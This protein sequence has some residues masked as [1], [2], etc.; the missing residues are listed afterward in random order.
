MN[1][2]PCPHSRIGLGPQL[3][4]YDAVLLSISDLKVPCTYHEYHFGAFYLQDFWACLMSFLELTVNAW[5]SR[6]LRL[7]GEPM[8]QERWNTLQY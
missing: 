8:A 4:N 2:Y 5:L 1:V 6:H 3:G 7:R